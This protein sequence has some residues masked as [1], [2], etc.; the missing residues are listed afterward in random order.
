MTGV[1]ERE[2]QLAALRSYAEEARRGDGRLALISGEA[3]IGKSTLVEELETTLPDATWWW[4]ACD[5]LSTPRALGPLTDIAT[6]AGGALYAA[7]PWTAHRATLAS[8]RCW[9]CCTTVRGLRVLVIEDLH[10]ADD[11]TLDMLRF[12]AR[13]IRGARVLVLLTYRDDALA[14]DEPLRV[15]L[16]DLAT[17]RTTRRVA[18]GPLS[19]H[20]VGATRRGQRTSTRPH[21]T[22]LTGGSPFFVARC[23]PRDR[24]ACPARRAT[25]CWRARP[26]HAGSARRARPCG[27]DRHAHHPVTAEPRRPTTSDELITSGTA[28][29]ATATHCG[30][31]TRSR[32]R[33]CRTRSRRT[34]RPSCTER[35]RRT[36]RRRMHRRRRASRSTPTPAGDTARVLE[37]APRAGRRP[38]L[39]RRTGRRRRSSS[40]PCGM[41]TPPT[42]RRAPRCTTSTPTNSLW[43]SDGTTP[44]RSSPAAIDAVARRPATRCARGRRDPAMAQ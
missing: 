3:G 32:D 25:S 35:P 36:A 34:R 15:T 19:Q 39:S 44:R 17:H 5:G 12:L 38:P 24:S 4:G 8:M 41:P 18:L 30:S 16:G 9:R 10:W 42:R 26:A 20:A 23:S 2:S 14:P 40:A 43:S 11:A 6:Q 31:G 1:L 33:R 28:R 37:H 27:A 13:R 7:L 29:R 22:E 21:C